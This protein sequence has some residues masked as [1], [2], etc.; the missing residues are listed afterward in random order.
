M[1][2]IGRLTTYVTREKEIPADTPL[3]DESKCSTE[4][5]VTC[6]RGINEV[7]TYMNNV[8]RIRAAN[9][10]AREQRDYSAKLHAEWENMTGAF[11][12]LQSLTRGAGLEAKLPD[13]KVYGGKV[14][15]DFQ[16]RFG[17]SCVLTSAVNKDLVCQ[18]QVRFL[19][20]DNKD[21]NNY[22][23]DQTDD[24]GTAGCVLGWYYYCR[25]KRDLLIQQLK[26]HN[27]YKNIEPNTNFTDE[28]YPQPPNI[29]ILCC[30]QNFSNIIGT[31]ITFNDI[32][33]NCTIESINGNTTP[34]NPTSTPTSTPTTAAPLVDGLL[35]GLIATAVVVVIVVVLLLILWSSPPNRNLNK[36][37]VGGWT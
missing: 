20:E 14:L 17:S 7:I 5:C 23:H 13:G 9:E 22:E 11:Q 4:Q 24:T 31:E 10:W 34:T 16:I 6:T 36:K 30:S 12:F 21:V 33:N 32:K 26:A 29:N 8:R 35:I 28:P 19:N 2:L 15:G 18:E 1:A 37:V 3:L 25:K 27:D